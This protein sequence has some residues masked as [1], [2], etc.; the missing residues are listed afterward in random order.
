MD[1]FSCVFFLKKECTNNAGDYGGFETRL[2]IL[3]HSSFQHMSLYAL[4]L[5]P[6]GLAT[7]STNRV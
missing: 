5:N 6:D 7:A 3:Q 1:S 4:C 2:Q